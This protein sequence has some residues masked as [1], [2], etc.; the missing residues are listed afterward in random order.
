MAGGV[1]C[2]IWSGSL[3]TCGFLNVFFERYFLLFYLVFFCW[4]YCL[5]LI[6]FR[7][8]G[9]GGCLPASRLGSFLVFPGFLEGGGSNMGRERNF[10]GYERRLGAVC[11]FAFC[12]LFFFCLFFSCMD[13]MYGCAFIV[14]GALD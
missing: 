5:V 7:L 14:P 12:F 1:L 11:V 4:D 9:F 2:R 6:P 13:C 10:H 8:N 3:P